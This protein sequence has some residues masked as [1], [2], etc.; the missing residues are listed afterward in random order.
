MSFEHNCHLK[1]PAQR[2]RSF[3][4]LIFLYYYYPGVSGIFPTL[5]IYHIAELFQLTLR[6][7]SGN[8]RFWFLM[9]FSFP[10]HPFRGFMVYLGLD[11]SIL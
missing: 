7:S 1:K 3:L 6:F 2:A 5:V 4:S 9:C 10:G 8:K 11:D